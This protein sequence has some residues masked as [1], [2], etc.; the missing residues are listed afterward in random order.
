MGIL[1]IVVN[2]EINGSNS[3]GVSV[4]HDCCWLQCEKNKPNLSAQPF[5]ATFGPSY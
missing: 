1:L 4:S 2:E 3:H 5:L